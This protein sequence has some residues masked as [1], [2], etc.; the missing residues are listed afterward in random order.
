MIKLTLNPISIYMT[1]ENKMSE[2]ETTSA[3]NWKVITDGEAGRRGA[4]CAGKMSPRTF[5][6]LKG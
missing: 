2:S 3:S 5:R 4:R 6:H 1:H